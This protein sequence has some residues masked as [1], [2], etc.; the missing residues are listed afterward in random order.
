MSPPD[1]QTRLHDM[2]DN[3]LLATEAVKNKVRSDLDREPILTAALERFVEIIGEAA[4]RV[5]E[6]RRQEL[7]RIPWRA[8]VGMRNRLV[9]GYGAV[10][11]DILWNVVGD[12]LSQLISELEKELPDAR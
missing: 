10:D 11:R 4:S 1:D 2:L 9:H 12:D 5:S 6:E 3:A 7:E 8:I